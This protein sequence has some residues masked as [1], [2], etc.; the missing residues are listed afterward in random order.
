[1]VITAS[2][3]KVAAFAPAVIQKVVLTTG[4][5]LDDKIIKVLES[6]GIRFTTNPNEVTHL[7]ADKVVRTVKFLA[8]MNVAKFVV[9][10]P[11]A[12]VSAQKKKILRTF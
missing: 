4:I 11:W 2:V 10:V 8:G 3:A 7:L 6:L 12:L 1:L 5:A 9:T